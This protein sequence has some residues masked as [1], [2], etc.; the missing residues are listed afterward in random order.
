MRD[1]KAHFM[2]SGS[3]T[4]FA[5]EL[6][7]Q[8]VVKLRVG[9][10]FAKQLQRDAAHALALRLVDGEFLCQALDRNITHVC[11]VVIAF[12]HFKQNALAQCALCN[13]EFF[14]V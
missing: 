11:G 13:I 3:P 5:L 12:H 9:N 7:H 6:L 14:N 2:H 8:W 10:G 1:G 4:E